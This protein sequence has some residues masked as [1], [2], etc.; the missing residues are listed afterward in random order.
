[1]QG[2]W[3]VFINRKSVDIADVVRVWDINRNA[4]PGYP[5][6]F[7]GADKQLYQIDFRG[8]FMLCKR[9]QKRYTLGYHLK[10]RFY[11]LAQL[12]LLLRRHIPV[13]P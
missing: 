10:S 1:M 4:E 7:F 9:Q 3:F 12:L 5:T 8:R 11:S 6:Y 2:D 13:P